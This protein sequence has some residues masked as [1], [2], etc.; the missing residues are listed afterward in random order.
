MLAVILVAFIATGITA[1]TN[2]RLQNR[3]YHESRLYR[4]EEA[5]NRSL[6]YFLEQKGGNISQD[7]IVTAFQDKICELSDVHNLLINIY[8]LRGNILISSNREKMDSIGIAKKV[9]YTILKQL[10]TGNSRAVIEKGDEG[11]Y[12][13]MAFWYFR[14]ANS[15]PLAIV[16]VPYFD[17]EEIKPQELK[18]FLYGLASVYI[19]LFVITGLLAYFLANYIT[20]SLHAI[21]DSLRKVDIGRKNDAIKWKGDDEIGALVKEYNRM[22]EALENSLEKLAKSERE[23]AWREMA[24]QVAHEI[25]NPLTP[26]KLRI[27]HLQRAWEDKSPEFDEKLK[28]T[29]ESII[30]QIDALSHIAGE[31]SRFAQLPTPAMEEVDLLAILKTSVDLFA[32][33]PDI[34]FEWKV[35]VG[36][37]R[38]LLDK[39][40]AL[41]IFNNLINNAVQSIPSGQAGVICISV[42]SG[43]GNKLN[44]AIA[45]NGTGILE[46]QRGRIFAPNFTTKS[47]GTGLGLAMVKAMTEQNNGR[48]WFESE[49]GRGSTFFLEFAGINAEDYRVSESG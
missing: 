4:K 33:S 48:V 29:T 37:A 11:S 43:E 12:Y 7:S 1:L 38:A 35:S 5:V 23:S 31:F 27:Q 22:L 10:S 13:L 21:A 19:V 45:D 28:R 40:Q 26:M 14:G 47:T 39:D 25:K 30:E 24:R 2:Y 41:R 46:E 32:A 17:T 8:D 15:K 44:I 18:E 49:P 3:E 9:D 16:S 6:D 34:R 36:S 20:K 42:E